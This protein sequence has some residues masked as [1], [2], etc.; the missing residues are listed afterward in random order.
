MAN[1]VKSKTPESDKNLW[2]TTWEC[3]ADSKAL[4]WREFKC[5]VAALPATAKCTNIIVPPD[6]TFMDGDDLLE[7]NIVGVDALGTDWPDDWWCNPP[8]DDKASF[9]R[10][11][12]KQQS[13]GRQGM[14]L[15]PYEPITGWWRDLLS[16][17]VIIYEP[18]GRYNFYEADGATKKSGVNFGS[19]FVLFPACKIGPSI[20]VPFKRGIGLTSAKESP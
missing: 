3:F 8:F 2:A 12:R 20:R 15:L 19:A 11:A 10:H 14:M 4:Y 1:L 9:I 13:A 18:N 5:D 7:R 16:D 6:Y 17:D